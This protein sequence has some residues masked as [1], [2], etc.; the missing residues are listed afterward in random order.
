MFGF[1]SK[2]IGREP[3]IYLVLLRVN[4]SGHESPIKTLRL[5][6]ENLNIGKKLPRTATNDDQ[7]N[8]K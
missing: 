5:F 6:G 7:N 8:G 3:D 4:T 1:M 2:I